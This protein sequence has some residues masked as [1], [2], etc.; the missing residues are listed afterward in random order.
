M[1]KP[2][3]AIALLLPLFLSAQEKFVIK[4][5]IGSL[6]APARAFLFYWRPPGFTVVMDSAVLVNGVFEF[7]S[8]VPYPLEATLHLRR[9]GEGYYAKGPDEM[10]SFYLENGTITITGDSL[11]NATLKAGVENTHYR[12]LQTLLQ[13]VRNK[14]RQFYRDQYALPKDQRLA[15]DALKEKALQFQAEERAA[16]A[17]FVRTHTNSFVSI[18]LLRLGYGKT[19]PV[20]EVGPLYH[21]L[22]ARVRGSQLG[23]EYGATIALWE[24]AML[25]RQAPDFTLTDTLSRPVSLSDFK[26]QYVLLNFWATWCGPCIQ[27]KPFLKKTYA[28]YRGKNFQILDVSMTDKSGKYGDRDKWIK[29]VHNFGLPWIN[30]YGDAAVDLYG[31]ET[32]PQNFL[33]DPAGKVIGH[34]VHK[35]ELDKKLEELLNKK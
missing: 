10:R 2:I 27:E 8:S 14:S 17:Q 7:K 35:E 18:N 31:I 21:G 19:P 24:K 32:V 5:K 25:G 3:V 30:V 11:S 9:N 34:D 29:M 33:I 6:N 4:G 20:A 1:K 22:S 12:Q 26:G 28:A 15:G 23:K 16:Y 13:P